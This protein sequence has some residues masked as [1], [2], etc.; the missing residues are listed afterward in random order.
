MVGLLFETLR[1]VAT[2]GARAPLPPFNPGLLI[3]K[4]EVST[5]IAT[6]LV[7]SVCM[8]LNYSSLGCQVLMKGYKIKKIFWP[9]IN[10]HKRKL[11]YFVNRSIAELSEKCQNWTFKIN[12]LGQKLWESFWFFH[13]KLSIFK[14]AHF[15]SLTLYFLKWCP[16]FDNPQLCLFTKYNSFL[17]ECWFLIFGQKSI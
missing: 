1:S 4:Q 15:L 17:I 8:Y 12:F 6:I 9:K 14:R 2:M 13:W 3:W 7:T 10:I 5:F 16:I 11:L